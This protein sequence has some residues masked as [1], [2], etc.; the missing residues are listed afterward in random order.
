MDDG[1]LGMKTVAD[2]IAEW[3][4]EKGIHTVFGIVGGGNTSLFE[5]IHKHGRTRIVC[6][7]HEQASVMAAAA[8]YRISGQISAALVTTGAGSTNAITG[9][10]AAWMDST[11]VIV[12]SGNEAWKYMC[13]PTR[14]WGVQGF[15]SSE[16]V[17]SCTK[18]SARMDGALDLG[19]LDF[20][21]K[22]ALE[23]RQGPVW[24]DIPKDAQNAKC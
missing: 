8:F 16:M 1:T 4:D 6:N 24:L 17:K 22:M 9:V 14:V 11:P 2:K 18:Y 15:G 7:H 10:V 12:I 13:A 19:N 5:A 20:V 3:L 23:P 21:H